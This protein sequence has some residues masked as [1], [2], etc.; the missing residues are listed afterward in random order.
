MYGCG[1]RVQVG[2]REGYTGGYT[3]WVIRVPTQPA[4]FARGEVPMTAERAP[5]PSLQGRVEWVVMGSSGERRLGDGPGTT[6]RARSGLP[7]ALPVPGPCR[8]HL[9]EI[10]DPFQ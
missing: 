4:R 8:S 5:E 7:E 6:L 2:T 9:G 10:P 3:G 1:V